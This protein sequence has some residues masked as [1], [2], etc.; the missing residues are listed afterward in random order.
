MVDLPPLY[1][2]YVLLTYR[3]YGRPYLTRTVNGPV[4]LSRYWYWTLLRYLTSKVNYDK[5]RA[6]PWCLSTTYF[7]VG[8]Q[9]LN[10]SD[11]SDPFPDRCI[12]LQSRQLR[13]VGF[14]WPA[15]EIPQLLCQF[16]ALLRR[17]K[18]P[19][20]CLPVQTLDSLSASWIFSCLPGWSL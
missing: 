18:A 5:P 9:Y 15:N 17:S 20:C 3:R 2:P 12:W 1:H 6:F 14:L 4:T 13:H 7:W 10:T 16:Q 11:L 8:N 19:S